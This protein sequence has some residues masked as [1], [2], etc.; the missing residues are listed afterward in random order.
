M[1]TTDH[2]PFDTLLALAPTA[3]IDPAGLGRA[4][5]ATESAIRGRGTTRLQTVARR[6][7]RSHRVL[8]VAAISVAAAA[9]SLVVPALDLGPDARSGTVPAFVA[10]QPAAAQAQ[11]CHNELLP[12]PGPSDP[13]SPVTRQ[14]WASIPAISRVLWT[15]PGLTL[16][17]GTVNESPGGCDA[18]PV[19]VLYSLD[20]HSGITI[21][22]DVTDVFSDTPEG[23]LDAV[24]VQGRPGRVLTPPAG[25]HYLTWKDA[26]GMQWYAEAGGVTL[27]QLVTILDESLDSQGLASVPAGYASAA[28]PVT[29]PTE[30]VFR[31]SAT[32]QGHTYLDVTTPVRAPVQAAFAGQ[33]GDV[34]VE[35]TT[36]GPWDAVY[37]PN[38]QGG[39]ELRWATDEA[40]FRLVSPGL[41]LEEMQSLAASLVPVAADDPALEPDAG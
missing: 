28:I 1:T 5:A 21:Y 32:Y 19:A 26:A 14:S 24:T 39:S 27:D 7:V 4:R 35:A 29:D 9:V 20:Q 34:T 13:D 17:A 8:A 23:L 25:L 10:L 41:G 2:D 6:R 30:T 40:S 33:W 36:V 11:G 31:W 18:R 12:L 3:P 37:L 16:T 22:R 15:A 38:G